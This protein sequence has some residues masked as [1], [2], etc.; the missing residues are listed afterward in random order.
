M[1][2][3]QSAPGALERLR[4]FVNSVDL[5]SGTDQLDGV[6]NATAWLAAEW[7]AAA[8]PT[9]SDVARLIAF[10]EQL[11][12]VLL[13]HNGDADPASA[14]EALAP[15]LAACELSIAVGAPGE[16]SLA[17]LSE[18]P[19]GRVIGELAG[20][21]YDAVRDQTWG[22]LKACRKHSCQWAFYD[23]SKNGSGAWCSMAVCGNRAKAARRR[24][25]EKYSPGAT[26][27]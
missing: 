13:A 14:W 6:E 11:R 19:S 23:H 2:K 24:Q 25:R 5:E 4:H 16:V 12:E 9:Q 27:H 26:S 22:R 1:P 8:Q 7:P 3:D 17:S 18:R 10:R 20:I 15:H 21:L